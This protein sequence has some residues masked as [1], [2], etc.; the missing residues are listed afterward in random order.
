MVMVT[1]SVEKAIDIATT[2]E[3]SKAQ[4][5]TM[6]NEDASTYIVKAQQWKLK[7]LNALKNNN[8]KKNILKRKKYRV[9][10]VTNVNINMATNVSQ[11]ESGVPSTKSWTVSQGFAVESQVPEKE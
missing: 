2:E 7:K 1:H 5:E 11:K 8:K 4:L 6:A 3:M 10:S 9:K